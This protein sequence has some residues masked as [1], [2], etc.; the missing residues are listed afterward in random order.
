MNKR[1]VFTALFTICLLAVVFFLLPT[2]AHATQYAEGN[3]TYTVLNEEATIKGFSDTE[4]TEIIIPATLGGYPVTAIDNHAFLDLTNLTTITIPDSVV[5]IGDWSFSGCTALTEIV[6]PD[7]VKT[8]GHCAFDDCIR[9]TSVTIPA[10]VTNIKNYA[11]ENCQQLTAVYITDI[12]AWCNIYFG[13]IGG[14]ALG[15]GSANP[16]GYAHELYCNGELVTD[17]VIPSGVTAIG[18]NAF[19]GCTSITSVVFSDSVTDIGASAFSGCTGIRSISLPN[20]ETIEKSTFAGCSGIT[21][22]IIPDSVKAIGEGAFSSC[23]RLTNVTLGKNVKTIDSK[24]FSSCAKL[25]RITFQ[26]GMDKIASDAFEKCTELTTVYHKGTQED[27]EFILIGDNNDYLTN[28]TIHHNFACTTHNWDSN[29]VIS[30][31]TC[32]EN[33]IMKYT[34]TVCGDTKTEEIPKLSQHTYVDGTCSVCGN[35]QPTEQD[36][37]EEKVGFFD[38]IAKFF[39][40]IFRILF[41]FLYL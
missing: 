12:A 25:S 26:K 10:S 2:Q 24:A 37:S 40:S 18:E 41:F 5:T 31:A 23:S 17:L 1:N 22:V 9:L 3:F 14:Y 30:A 19:S 8:I 7:G 28:A 27:W 35:I 11:F 39:E 4:V 13:T 21:S 15:R 16:L 20:I 34:C 32:V 38:A 29:K 6:I 36:E 33:G